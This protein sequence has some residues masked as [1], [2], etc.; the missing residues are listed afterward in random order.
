MAS[1]MLAGE[2]RWASARRGGMTVLG[3]VAVPKPLNLPS[4]RLENHGLDQS[5]ESVPKG[6][7][8]W[9]SRSSSSASNAWCSSALSPNA[10]GSAG[11]PRNLS[12]RPSSSEGS[13]RPSSAGSNRMHE[14]TLSAWGPHSRPSSASGALTSNQTSLMSSRPRSAETRPGSSQLSRFAGLSSDNS[15]PCGR[16]GTT[17]KL[18]VASTKKDG[19]SLSSGDFPTLGS[20][21][22]NSGRNIEPQESD[23]YGRPGSS[24]SRI[25]SAE[26]RNATSSVGDA[27]AYANAKSGTAN[28]WKRDNSHHDE[29]GFRP[30]VEKWQGDPQP[31]LNTN[32]P[33]P[34]FDAWHGPPINAPGGVWYRGPPGGPPYGPPVAPGGFPIEP[35][36]YY[37]PQIPATALANSHP[38][39]PPGAG[40]RGPHPKNG[41]LYRPHIPDAYIR[42]GMPIRPG[43]YP[44]P[45]AYEGYY[46]PAMGYCNSNERDIPFMGMQARPSVYNRYPN[47]NAPDP[48]NHHGTVGTHGSTGRQAESGH[49]DNTRGPVLLKHRNEWG[50]KE[51]EGDQPRVYSLKNEWGAG[52]KKN[53]KI[54]SGRSTL[55]EDVPSRTSNNRAGYSSDSVKVKLPEHMGN[56]KAV[57]D[58]LVK[59]SGNVA[60][61]LPDVPQIIPATPKDS[62]LMQKIEDLNA[63]ARASDGRHDV[64]SSSSSEEQNSRLQVSNA[65]ANISA[66]AVGTGA[67][68]T[69]RTH[70]SGDLI[71]VSQEVDVSA[72]D[73]TLQ[74]GV[75][76]GTSL[77]RR[78][79][80]GMQGRTD[81]HS[82]RFNTKDADG[83][84]KKSLVSGSLNAV[85]SANIGPTFNVHVEHHT[86]VEADEKSGIN[87]Q[88]KDE[89]ESLTLMYD[90]SDC[91]AQRAKMR[92]IAK[93]RAKL[94]Q[95]E[96]EERT[97]EQKAKA[98]AK[99]E[100]LNRRIQVADGSTQKFEKVLPGA[101]I[102]QGQEVSQTLAEPVMVSSKYEKP[103]SSLVFNPNAVAQISK[104]N[105]I[106]VELPDTAQHDPVVPCGQPLALQHDAQNAVAAK[107]KAASQVNDGG[108]SRQK[109]LGFKQKLNF[110]SEMKVTE[111]PIPTI[112]AEAPKIN[113][114]V[115]VDDNTSTEVVSEVGP[116][117]EPCSPINP[118]IMTETTTHQRRKNNR[119]SKNKHKLETSV[120]TLPSSAPKDANPAK[121]SIG[122]GESKASEFELDP[123]SVQSLTD[124]KHAIQPSEQHS[125]LPSE[126]ATGRVNNHRKSQQ[127]RRM[128]RNPQA[129][130]SAKFHSSDAVVWAPV[131][132]QNKSE[133]TDEASQ[134]NS[135]DA[136]APA[137]K[138]EYLVQNNLKSKRA[139]MER[140]VPKPVAK[141]LA[142]QGSVQQPLSSSIN[143]T[144]SDETVGRAEPGFQS[145]ESSQSA[146][147]AIGNILSTECKNG[148][149]KQNKQSK[150]HGSWRLRVS[151]ESP[152]VKEL[153]DGSSFTSDPGKN[154]Q[155][156]IDQHQSFIPDVNS[157]EG[158]PKFSD[159]S[160]GCNTK[161]KGVIDRG[162]RHLFKGH[163]SSNSY[164][165]HDRR[166]INSEDTH[167]SCQQY[168]APEISQADRTGSTGENRGVGERTASHWQPKSQAYSAHYQRGS[169]F[170]GDGQNVNAEVGRAI[171]KDFPSQDR[172]HLPPHDKESSEITAQPHLNQSLSEEKSV[173]EAQN[174]GHPE[175]RREKKVA[176]F[177]GRSH[178]PNQDHANTVE[179]AP[180]ADMDTQHEQRSSS[181]FHKN[182]NP[183]NRTSRGHESRGEWSS[184]GQ[185]SKQ[186]NI[187]ANRERQR[188]NS[189][190]EYQPVGPYNNSK[191]K[192]FEGQD[193]SHNSSSRYRDRGQG[194]STRGGGNFYGRQ[195]S[196]VRANTGYD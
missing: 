116:S 136:V 74:A 66:N 121:I 67:V 30:G 172:V 147:S 22:D 158:Q 177:K 150:A 112:S 47:Q 115:A 126:E 20:E 91:D 34:H 141:E 54:H 155:K 135:H 46:G 110:H 76:S 139:E 153:Q 105:T 189:H 140:Y 35:F 165:D 157:V 86:F 179:L 160:E 11:S 146:N 73:K 196:N 104:G 93:Q 159:E 6:T 29:D 48:N 154:V 69:K 68:Y 19:F 24:S 17:E 181:G 182:G 95:K 4:Q 88:S 72:R 100:E 10:D 170:V 18:G 8:S 118:N 194:H 58:I 120:T 59:K 80:H 180:P 145:I 83:W 178:S 52:H 106:V 39:P 101:A 9:G 41:D 2:R 114:D 131:L 81:H 132:S 31:Y 23:S 60:S 109:R 87:L 152:H 174:V 130:R 15:V 173:V 89:E 55:S 56:G 188:Q 134:K 13:T 14:P 63:K 65:K 16:P 90:P 5:M 175:A 1:S 192:N 62:T 7:L 53:E 133:V 162:N 33:P 97:R 163:R 3:R 127:S 70:A 99:L 49:P 77:S 28:T 25:S 43:F 107:C 36:P 42:P 96:E 143:Q 123:K 193:G 78:A 128:P 51:D 98:L 79:S 84:Q 144:T 129:I 50:G 161:D 171:K 102:P 21:R 75:A 149:S 138:S 37:R 26:E 111:E 12:G 151:S 142:Q 38:I 148:N 156:S 82:K 57:E 108:V 119:S 122:G 117:C 40:P 64:T 44:G 137:A 184:A 61:A 166:N 124:A 176:S 27:S 195:S 191:S 85:S 169:R 103:S 164:Y 94:L 32:V 183:N 187:P 125:V 185:E 186:H 71:L 92:E 167:K 45:V 113:S 190:Y 168:A